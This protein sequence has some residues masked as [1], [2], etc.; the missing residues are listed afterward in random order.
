MRLLP[1]SLEAMQLMPESSSL[2]RCASAQAARQ[3]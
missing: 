2:L 3:D 1:E